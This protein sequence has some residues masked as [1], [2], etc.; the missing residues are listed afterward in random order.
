MATNAKYW[1][2]LG[3]PTRRA[4]FELL[5]D[6]P[7]SVSGL[8]NVLPVTRPAVSQHL[9]VLKDAGLVADTRSGK[10]RIYRIDPDGLAAFRAEIDQFW[11]KALAAYA[12]VV[13][14]PTEDET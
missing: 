10:E 4:I 3:D 8:A 13:D 2:A 6:R 5:V 11:S 12:R 14:Q 7:S 9:K 1:T